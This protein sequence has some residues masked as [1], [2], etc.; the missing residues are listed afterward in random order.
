[1]KIVLHQANF[2]SFFG[3]ICSFYTRSQ[4]SHASIITDEAWW[5]T[6]FSRGYFDHREV[7]PNRNVLVFDLPDISGE[8]WCKSKKGRKYDRVGLLLYALDLQK[9]DED[10]CYENITA[11]LRAHGIKVAVGRASPKKILDALEGYHFRYCKEGEVR[12]V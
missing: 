6:T 12:G 3:L 10:F 9:E 1:M 8:E 7:E 2:R 5:D 11:G 4:W